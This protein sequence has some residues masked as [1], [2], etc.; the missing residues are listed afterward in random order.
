MLSLFG[1]YNYY[2]IDS[3]NTQPRYTIY[4]PRSCTEESRRNKSQG[5]QRGEREQ[6]TRRLLRAIRLSP[7]GRLPTDLD[8]NYWPRRTIDD[9]AAPGQIG[10]WCSSPWHSLG[11]HIPPRCFKGQ[12]S[13]TS[14]NYLIPSRDGER[15]DVRTSL[16]VPATL[17]SK[18]EVFE[19]S[20]IL[21]KVRPPLPGKDGKPGEVNLIKDSSTLISFLYP[22]QNKDVVDTLV[23]KKVN[24][25]AMEMIPR[26]SR[27]QV[28]DALR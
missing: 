16:R 4:N 6:L 28:F 9:R 2:T 14:S 25:L 10:A 5:E 27:A 11:S 13:A 26:I 19:Q 8:T 15:K 20:D 22:A 21:L 1:K 24:A 18:E 12:D 7:L 17:V 23:Q 3:T